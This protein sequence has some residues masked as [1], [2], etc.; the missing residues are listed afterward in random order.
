MQLISIGEGQILIAEDVLKALAYFKV[1]RESMADDG[2]KFIKRKSANESYYFISNLSSKAV[3]KNIHL[4]TIAKQLVLM[5]PLTGAAG[6]INFTTDSRGSNCR[7]SLQPGESIIVKASKTIDAKLN[8]WIYRN[9]QMP[10]E[11][12]GDWNLHFIE[13]GPVLPADKKLKS[14][15][16]WTSISGDSTLQ[17]F[18]GIGSYQT[19]F[20]L[21][22]KNADDYLISISE[23]NESAKIIVNG[24]E[25]G[26]IW[27]LPYQLNIGK[28]LKQGENTIAIEVAN[29]MANRIRY[30]D[31][32]KMVWRIFNEI[33][34]V[35]IN[36]KPFDASN[37][38][39]Q[40]SGLGAVVQIIPISQKIQNQSI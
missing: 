29:L 13:G 9:E 39:L 7:I 4:T 12:N 5:N 8:N 3:D 40:K 20:N 10:I 26:I 31:K 15:Q 11:L 32:N 36:Y 33:N 24:K 22:V 17:N 34:F 1:E 21:P 30:M 23:I 2:L 35:D 28:F 6:K 27:S 18:S 37:W 14:L 38:K 25:A 19:K 16:A